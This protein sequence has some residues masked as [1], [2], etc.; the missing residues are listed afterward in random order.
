MEISLIVSFLT[1]TFLEVVLGIDNIIFMSIVSDQLPKEKQNIARNVGLGIATLIR[2]ML[3]FAIVWVNKL[4]T[5]LISYNGFNLTGKDIVLALG[6]FFL[7]YKSTGEI[8]SASEGIETSSK[9]VPSFWS[10]IL[11]ITIINIV[12]SFDSILTA[13]GLTS[14]I[15]I[16]AMA[17][18]GST[19]IMIFFSKLVSTYIE[20]YKSLKV[21]ALSFILMV[22]LFL[23][24]DASHI[25]VPKGYI[26]AAIGFSLFVEFINIR[27][28][29]RK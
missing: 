14:N 4:E 7:M 15:T 25:Y 2:I 24:L 16:M 19:V 3:L 11:Q 6:G 13:I 12:F 9:K 8:F 20:K 10:A 23:I 5:T 28:K 29:H 27:F 17:I 22:G 18:L 1:L 26:Y 21:L